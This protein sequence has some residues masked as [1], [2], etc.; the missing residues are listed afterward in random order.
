[1]DK[2]KEVWKIIGYVFA[3]GCI[4]NT[5]IRFVIGNYFEAVMFFSAAVLCCPLFWKWISKYD[6]V[7][8]AVV[9]SLVSVLFLATGFAS[10]RP[11]QS[12][13]TVSAPKTTTE[14]TIAETTT[15]A[16]TTAETTVTTTEEETTVT[17]TEETT[18]EETTISE[19]E[20]VAETIKEET[21]KFSPDELC[22]AMKLTLSTTFDSVNV[23]YFES[24]QLYVCTVSKNG[25][26]TMATAVMDGTIEKSQWDEYVKT[27][28][29]TSR[30]LVDEMNVYQ[31][32]AHVSII[33][34][35]DINNENYL[36]LYTDGKLIE[37][38]VTM[39]MQ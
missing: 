20:T 39:D 21:V 2:K 16:T 31:L 38:T 1:M 36:L 13:Q 27:L 33:V 25:L 12:N 35:N 22:D 4:A 6:K 7:M 32:G 37:D 11:Q 9:I 28:Q 18:A 30:I 15:K 5:I 24:E 23:G 19:K 10:Q 26:A 17:T 34:V 3:V 14:T 29:K 8:K